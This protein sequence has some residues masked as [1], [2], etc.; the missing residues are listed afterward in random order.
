MSMKTRFSSDDQVVCYMYQRCYYDNGPFRQVDECFIP[1]EKICFSRDK[2]SKSEIPN[3]KDDG[4]FESHTILKRMLLPTEWVG[5][6]KEKL[7]KK[8]TVNLEESATENLFCESPFIEFLAIEKDFEKNYK[9]FGAFILPNYIM[10][11]FDEEENMNASS[12]TATRILEV[13]NSLDD[14]EKKSLAT[15][16]DERIR[17]LT[18]RRDQYRD[19]KIEF[20]ISFST[21]TV[22]TVAGVATGLIFKNVPVGI[23]AGGIA[24]FSKR[25]NDIF[26]KK[27][28]KEYCDKIFDFLKVNSK[29]YLPS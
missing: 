24:L 19:K 6:L 28:C 22:A 16:L 25:K 10:R 7:D 1:S 12:K 14:T 27:Q 23:F 29:Q 11:Y 2:V 4:F 21:G 3:N 26:H 18:K 8:D 5:K 13:I 9:Q 17:Y 20:P 15:C